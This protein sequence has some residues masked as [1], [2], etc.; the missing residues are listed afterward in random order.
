MNKGNNDKIKR[1]ESS[2]SSDFN[3]ALL[4]NWQ[5]QDEFVMNLEQ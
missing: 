2:E 3:P 1:K 4:K 5:S